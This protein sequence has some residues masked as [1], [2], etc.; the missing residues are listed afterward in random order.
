MGRG[1]ILMGV[2]LGEKGDQDRGKTSVF[3][4]GPTEAQSQAVFY[5]GF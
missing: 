2:L 5:S 1:G 3:L 4:L